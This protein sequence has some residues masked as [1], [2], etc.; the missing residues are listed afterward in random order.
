MNNNLLLEM[1]V[2]ESKFRFSN[3]I[4][5]ELSIAQNE[6]DYIDNSIQETIQSIENLTPQC[7]RID[8]VLASCSGILCGIIDIFLVGKPKDSILCSINDKW[9]KERIVDFSRINGYEGDINDTSSAIRF[10]EKK[11]KIPY[12]QTTGGEIFKD[13]INLTPQNH[14]FKSLGHNPTMLGLF[15]SIINQFDNTSSFVSNGEL[16]TLSNNDSIYELHGSN[17]VSKIYIGIVNW[18][19]HLLSDTSGSSSSVGRGMGIPSPIYSWAN[20]VIVIK[21]KMGISVSEFDK[22]YNEQALKIF[23]EGFDSRFQ[24]VQFIPVIINEMIVRLIYSIRRL[25]KYI[26]NTDKDNRSYKDIWNYCNPFKNATVNRML[27]IAHGTFCLVDIGEAVLGGLKEGSYVNVIIRVNVIG[28]SRF[29]I[30]LFKEKKN[31]FIINK[32]EENKKMLLDEKEL[33]KNYVDGL[34]ELSNIYDDKLLLMFVDDFEKSDMYKEGFLKTVL[35]AEK[36]NVPIDKILHDKNEID[37]YFEGDI[38][39]EKKED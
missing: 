12:D 13:Y 24:T 11:Y 29:T 23:L 26:H 17:V 22:Y 21:N 6:Y 34:K 32:C 18:I 33:L 25:T 5:R 8:Y 31:R 4:D 15:F 10:L 27:T 1:Q 36:R 14:H 7:D 39:Y 9:T 16:I 19:G 37:I 20:D 2:D 3:Y 38:N 35:L 28:I 30:S